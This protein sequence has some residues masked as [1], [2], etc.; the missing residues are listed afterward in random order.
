MLSTEQAPRALPF[1]NFASYTAAAHSTSFKG[2]VSD[3]QAMSSAIY[4]PTNIYF[5]SQQSRAELDFFPGCFKAYAICSFEVQDNTSLTLITSVRTK[6]YKSGL[7]PD[8][9]KKK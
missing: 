6:T 7:F 1:Q 3:S 9:K 5:P 2:K 8:T 4:S